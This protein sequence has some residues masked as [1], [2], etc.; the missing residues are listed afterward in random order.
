[1]SQSI[2]G[3]NILTVLVSKPLPEEIHEKK[4]FFCPYTKNITLQ[5]QGQ[6]Q[7]IYPS[8][9]PDETPQFIIHPQRTAGNINYSFR[10][11]SQNNSSV[12]FWIQSYPAD[13]MIK[14]Y[15][16]FNCQAQ[17]LYFNKDKV[18]H[19]QSKAEVKKGDRY[20]CVNPFCKKNQTFLGVVYI[21]D[22]QR[23]I[24]L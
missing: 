21:L 16:C 11:T 3:K 10:A 23:D 2:I 9:D 24:I 13:D 4:V 7:A 18:V 15:H 12:D 5:Y 1:M 20:S 6:V 14:P 19:F 17:S 22:I 8:Y